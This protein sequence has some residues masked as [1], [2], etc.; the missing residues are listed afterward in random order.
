MTP[1]VEIFFRNSTLLY[2]FKYMSLES[3]TLI[4]KNLKILAGQAQLDEGK[5][6]LDLVKSLDKELAQKKAHLPK[7]LVHFLENRSYEKALNFLS[8]DSYYNL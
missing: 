1:V 4:K 6:I 5:T 7:K 2:L 3:L 8:Q